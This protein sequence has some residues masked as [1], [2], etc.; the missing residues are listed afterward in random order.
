MV[1]NVK[2]GVLS[3]AAI[4]LVVML[5]VFATGCGGNASNAG[6]YVAGQYTGEGAGMAGPIKVTV[7]VD[8]NKITAAT[9]EDSGETDGIPGRKAIDDG[10]FVDQI[11]DAQ[12]SDIDGVSGATI[13]SNGIRQGVE[14]ALEEAKNPDFSG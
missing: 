9:I 12:S 14:L 1:T 7:T 2:R 11:L 6:K 3:L 10:T 5:S 4:A 13:T 8:D